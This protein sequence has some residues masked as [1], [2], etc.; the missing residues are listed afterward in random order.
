MAKKINWLKRGPVGI[1]PSGA[2]TFGIREIKHA[3]HYHGYETMSKNVKANV[4]AF[5]QQYNLSAKR[6][7]AGRKGFKGYFPEQTMVRSKYA[8]YGK[9]SYAVRS[10]VKAARTFTPGGIAVLA[11]EGI[12]KG[13]KRA[14]GPGGTEF[15]TKKSKNKYG[16][17]GY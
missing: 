12:Y 2:P 3:Y 16:T 14:L 17:K 11:A 13:T 7:D 4:A 5:N 9:G 6:I 10:G 8:K 1:H 15:H